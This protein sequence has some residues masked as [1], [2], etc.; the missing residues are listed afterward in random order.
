MQNQFSML[1]IKYKGPEN[2]WSDVW[3]KNHIYFPKAIS[4]KK[5]TNGCWE[6]VDTNAWKTSVSL[7]PRKLPLGASVFSISA[8]HKGCDFNEHK[9]AI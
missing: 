6:D 9:A 8:R 4:K 1:V 7:S 3:I 5:S 2:L